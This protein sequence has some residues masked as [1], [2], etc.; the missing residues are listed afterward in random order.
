MLLPYHQFN[1]NDNITT[2]TPSSSFPTS[3]YNL[4]E[5]EQWEVLKQ[6][7]QY[8]ESS[9]I[10][11][12][13]KSSINCDGLTPLHHLVSKPTVPQS[14][15]LQFI[16]LHTKSLYMQ[17]K[18]LSIPLHYACES[19]SA[20]T[21]RTL[22]ES[23]CHFS[24]IGNCS[25][26]SGGSSSSG[27]CNCNGNGSSVI[28]FFTKSLDINERSPLERAWLAYLT[29]TE[30][31]CESNTKEKE[32]DDDDDDNDD[33]YCH[34]DNNNR[35]V[36][37]TKRTKRTKRR[38]RSIRRYGHYYSMNLIELWN[39][40]ELILYA[41]NRFTL[42][43]FD[44]RYNNH[45]N[46]KNM[47]NSIHTTTKTTT[48]MK[49]K[50]KWHVLHEIAKSGSS[51]WCPNIIMWF[52]INILG[53][54]HQLSIYDDNGDLPLHVSARSPLHK[55]LY[56]PRTNEQCPLMNMSVMEILITSYPDASWLRNK[57]EKMLP[58]HLAIMSGKKEQ[59]GISD[60]L[61]ANPNAIYDPEPKSMLYP[62]LLSSASNY[63]SNTTNDEF[64]TQMGRS[65]PS[66][67]Q[68][69]KDSLELTFHLLRSYPSLLSNNHYCEG[70][71]FCGHFDDEGD[72]Q[73]HQKHYKKRRFYK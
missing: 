16:S 38:R 65:L 54:R 26:S 32:Q 29:S 11:S 20:A 8:D 52:A 19:G 42:L 53:F 55:I 7:L 67:Q 56:I 22:L 66:P 12:S 70:M 71:D 2:H 43:D 49:E 27:N 62:F 47:N 60:L 58:L 31:K 68:R 30:H 63:R 33:D 3:I 51:C 23:L 50:K 24:S 57:G 36:L 4:I 39:K 25:S 5:S 72:D 41:S 61:K 10:Q 69:K 48:T 73:A 13:I 40:T 44:Q 9:W 1:T 6:A 59:D 64:S 34:D 37:P 46:T 15:V 35:N 21:V 28:Q 45:N 17:S 18:S 14:L